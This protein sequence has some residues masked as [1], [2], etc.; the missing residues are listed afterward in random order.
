M[1][2]SENVYG[3]TRDGF[4]RKR[5]P[6]ILSDINRRVS[7]RLGVEIET[8]SN[9]LFGQLHGVFAYEIADLWEQAENTYNAM[10]P[11]T[12][13]GTSL[14]N[15]AGLAGISPII[16]THSTLLATCY[17]D[18]GTVIPYGAQISSADT[19]GSAWQCIDNH[20]V[21]SQDNAV[22]AALTIKDSI[23]S[24]R[25]YTLTFN[26]TVYEKTAGTSDTNVTILVGLAANIKNDDVT[27][28][29]DNGI[30]SIRSSSAEKTF[31]LSAKNITITS[32]ASPVL[33]QSVATGAIDPN[34]GTLTKIIST[35]PGWTGVLN[36]DATNVGKA[37]ETDTE[38]R[39]RWNRSLYTRASAMTDAITAALINDVVGVTACMTFENVFDETDSDG[40]PPHSIEVVVEGGD[41]QTI[42]QKIFTTKAGGIDT[43]GTVVKTVTDEF[44]GTHT[45]QFN[46]PTQVKIWL[47]VVISGT[48]DEPLP[49]AATEEIAKALLEQGQTQKIGEDVILQ[50]YFSTIFKATQGV[51]YI[52]LTATTGDTAGTYSTNNISIAQ[53]QVAVFD[54]ARI[55]VTKSDT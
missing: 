9:S 12:A 16:G 40:R 24:G 32:L 48:P 14:S 53:R 38:L 27:T 44:G 43:F 41:E 50:R 6:E 35:I 49:T 45:I 3:L 51:G 31:S 39:Q 22:Y 7:D 4:R 37:A 2:D 46:R 10:Y 36:S 42:A 11:N 55:E 25:V 23:E 13:T 17:G 47:K 34:L 26:D 21:I 15:A 19:N 30:L 20:A 5:L 28:S 52:N 18:N 54:S 33:F 29:M 8:G 1:A